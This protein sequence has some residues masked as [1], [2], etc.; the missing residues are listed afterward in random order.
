V[1]SWRESAE[2]G[3]HNPVGCELRDSRGR[4]ER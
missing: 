3:G 4:R 2:G 1:Y